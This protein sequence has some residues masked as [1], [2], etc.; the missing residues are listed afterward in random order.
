MA[1]QERKA[2]EEGN[3]HPETPGDGCGG[4]ELQDWIPVSLAEQGGRRKYMG[5]E[6]GLEGTL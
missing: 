3:T 6:L 4:G 5:Q 2:K 1:V